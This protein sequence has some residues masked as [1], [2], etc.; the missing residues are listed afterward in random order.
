MVELKPDYVSFLI[1][2]WRE[3]DADREWLAQVEHI[4]SGEQLYFASLA[5]L[6]AYMRL[7]A[8]DGWRPPKAP[9]KRVF[10]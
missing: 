4:P 6:F 3:S 8:N 9:R 10:D 5:D 2:L 1:R 7:V